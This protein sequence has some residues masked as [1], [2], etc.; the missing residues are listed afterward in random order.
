MTNYI[1]KSNF[2]RITRKV[3]L[4]EKDI[5]HAIYKK[6]IYFFNQ[7]EEKKILSI[8]QF[9]VNAENGFFEFVENGF[10]FDTFTYVNEE[11]RHAKYHSNKDCEG[12]L[13]SFKDFEIP[14]EIKYK[15]GEST[16]DI[17]KV[18]DFRKWFKQ[19][20]IQD[21][22]TNDPTKFI[23]KLQIKFNLQNPPKSVELG[24]KGAQGLSNLSEAELE[25]Q[26][27]SYI[28]Q[29]SQHYNS[30]PK[31]RKILVAHNFSK[32]TYLVTSKKYRS[33]PIEPNNTGFS[34]EEVR[35]V[36][37]EFY[38]KIKKPIIDLLIDYWIIK[39]NPSL[40]FDQNILEQL[41]FKP[42]HLCINK[43]STEI[44]NDLDIDDSEPE[45]PLQ[46]DDRPF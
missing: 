39:L 28:N 15:A 34:D 17:E 45:E 29:A 19:L 2:I 25:K 12:L 18:E 11:A 35:E 44:L 23:D 26:I 7:F 43:K 30:S 21:L 40:D 42:C 31:I 6:N 4:D 1:T 32:K 27:D 13:S 10:F 14:V 36:L 3:K 5:K 46:Y 16:I 37:S 38:N 33:Q 8:K 24:G 22:F 20:E 41:D 9:L